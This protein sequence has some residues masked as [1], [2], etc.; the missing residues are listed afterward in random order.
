MTAARSYY[1]SP[2]GPPRTAERALF[3]ALIG[4]GVSNS[5]ACRRVGVNRKTGTRWL[6]G[7]TITNASGRTLHYPG[8]VNARPREISPRFLSEDE[9][10]V[11]ADRHRAHHTVR[12]IAA[13]LGRSPSTISRELRRNRDIAGGHYRPFG[14]HKLAGAR[15]PRPK[16][17]KL[18]RDEVL[19]SFVQDRLEKCWS[20]EQICQ[21][22]RVE[23]RD[24]PGR[25]LV[26]ETVYQALYAGDGTLR[27]DLCRSLRTGRRRRKPRRRADAR[28][29]N[30]F[31]DP[32]TLIEHR[33]AEA[34]DRAVVGHWE[35]DLLMG[36][37]NRSAIGTLVERSTRHVLLVHL[38]PSRTAEGVR[39]A[40]VGVVAELP[41]GL[42]R[43]LT[44]DQGK[45]MSRHR[46][47]TVATGMPVFFCERASPWQ[48]GT[49]ENTNG[50]LRQYFPKGTDLGHHSAEHLGAV[51]AELNTRPRKTLGWQTPTQR[52]TELLSQASRMAAEASRR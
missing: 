39:D 13:E 20:P 37:G 18:A 7:R 26:H 38:G 51:A 49:N 32:M 40:L 42:R 15:R 22:L 27:R 2:G 47:F 36:A 28:R 33:P 8:V 17:R 52:L 44:W 29:P 48:R 45:E 43:S 24:T 16:V 3:A 4:Q 21:A 14:A 10:V 41:E 23:F 1:R 31:I 12:A 9:R 50:L 25:H 19:R 46:D 34:A 35:G 5:E 30:G 6:Y 11:I